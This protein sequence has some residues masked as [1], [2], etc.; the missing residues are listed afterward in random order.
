MFFKLKCTKTRYSAGALRRT[1]LGEQLTS[2]R[3]HELGAAYGALVLTPLPSAPSTQIPGYASGG[4]EEKEMGRE[5][6]G[7][8][9]NTEREK[10]SKE[11]KGE[12]VGTG[13]PIG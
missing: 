8:I 4:K 3:R 1:P 11:G 10:R 7:R 12:E 2:L 5:K 9:R 13:P 6:Q